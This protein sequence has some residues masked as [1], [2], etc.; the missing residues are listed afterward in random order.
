LGV[1]FVVGLVLAPLLGRVLAP[2]LGRAPPPAAELPALGRV[3]AAGE[4]PRPDA[5]RSYPRAWSFV[6]RFEPAP[7]PYFCAVFESL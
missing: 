3:D 5:E 7:A 4:V 2:L 1:A 6:T